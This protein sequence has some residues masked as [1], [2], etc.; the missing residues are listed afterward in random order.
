MPATFLIDI[1]GCICENELNTNGKGFFNYR[2]GKKLSEEN[3]IQICDKSSILPNF[4]KFYKKVIE[5]TKNKLVFV[6]GRMK[7]LSDDTKEFLYSSGFNDYEIKFFDRKKFSPENYYLFKTEV[8]CN[9]WN[10]YPK[11][12][13]I[14]VDDNKFMCDLFLIFGKV[15]RG[16]L[17]FNVNDNEGWDKLLESKYFRGV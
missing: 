15:V 16:I 10:K 6:T 4:I 12:S 7:F 8:V 1:D 11:N 3:I 9:M 14:F 17:C 5:G 2:N 13:V